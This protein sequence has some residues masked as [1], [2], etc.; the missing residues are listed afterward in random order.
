MVHVG[1]VFIGFHHLQPFF[2]GAGKTA[3]YRTVNRAA[4]TLA[5]HDHGAAGRSA[6]TFLRRGDQHVYASGLHVHPN[7]P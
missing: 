2:Q 4:G 5:E 6:P 1:A 7:G 3:A